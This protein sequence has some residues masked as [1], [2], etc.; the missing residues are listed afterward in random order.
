MN[1]DA[2]TLYEMIMVKISEHFNTHEPE[3]KLNE[4][5]VLEYSLNPDF[6]NLEYEDVLENVMIKIINTHQDF[7]L[8]QYW[9]EY[10][11]YLMYSSDKSAA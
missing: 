6:I 4:L 11:M 3:V 9:Q 10:R 2:D 7:E 1:N 8:M 5:I